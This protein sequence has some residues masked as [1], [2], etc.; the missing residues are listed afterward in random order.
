MSERNPSAT[1]T[2]TI[3]PNCCDRERLAASFLGSLH[4]RMNGCA[5]FVRHWRNVYI[6]FWHVCAILRHLLAPPGASDDF[7][8]RRT[9]CRRLTVYPSDV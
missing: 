6:F 1:N 2:P 7:K 3:F 9:D 4:P 5:Q 8:A